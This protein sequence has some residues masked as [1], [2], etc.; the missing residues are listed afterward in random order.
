MEGISHVLIRSTVLTDILTHSGYLIE[1]LRYELEDSRL[2]N[3]S[4]QHS[5]E[6]EEVLLKQNLHLFFRH[7]LKTE[8]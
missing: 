3:R 8:S 2:R 5:T 6:R 7:E 4:A 1:G